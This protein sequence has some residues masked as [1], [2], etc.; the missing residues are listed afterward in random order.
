MQTLLLCPQCGKKEFFITKPDGKNVFFHVDRDYVPFP[1]KGTYED[2][3]TLD[4]S[5]IRCLGCSWSGPVRKLVP[6]YFGR[7]R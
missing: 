5:I 3:S 6:F 7:P 1:A 2:L 4:L